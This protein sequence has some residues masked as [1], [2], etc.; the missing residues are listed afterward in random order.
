MCS[1]SVSNFV[2]RGLALLQ[3]LV[4]ARMHQWDGGESYGPR[5]LIPI[6]PWQQPRSTPRRVPSWR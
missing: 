5:Y 3:V 6:L 2:V 1:M 4:I